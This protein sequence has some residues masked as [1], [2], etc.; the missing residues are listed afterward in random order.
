MPAK[1]KRWEESTRAEKGNEG[2]LF[3]LY[4]AKG[5]KGKIVYTGCKM[6]E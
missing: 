3:K 6:D 4:F 5:R 1:R 2:T